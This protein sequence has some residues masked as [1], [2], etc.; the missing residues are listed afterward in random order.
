ME[1]WEEC[2]EISKTERCTKNWRERIRGY[3]TQVDVFGRWLRTF[4][5]SLFAIA[6]T[7]P[8]DTQAG[9]ASSAIARE[10]QE[11]P[12]Q[13]VCKGFSGS[14]GGRTCVQQQFD[15]IFI[16]INLSSSSTLDMIILFFVQKLKHGAEKRQ[17]LQR[18]SHVLLLDVFSFSV[19]HSTIHT[20]IKLT[21]HR[22]IN[23]YPL[24]IEI[25]LSRLFRQTEDTETWWLKH[26]KRKQG[27]R[28]L[29]RKK[30]RWGR[31]FFGSAP[32]LSDEIDQY[33]NKA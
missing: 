2:G 21:E 6:R 1:F 26:A 12:S 9:S 31:C 27:L 22:W 15:F 25:N 18:R 30:D 16:A 19:V 13:I 14:E 24:Q 10:V 5:A 17:F 20:A 23:W 29:A 11:R 3:K 7:I 32:S 4:I 8:S 33:N 28:E